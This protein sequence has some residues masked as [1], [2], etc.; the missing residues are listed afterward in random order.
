MSETFSNSL[1]VTPIGIATLYK[2]IS[3]GGPC[4]EI[5]DGIQVT[6]NK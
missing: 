1:A 4:T 5:N 6:L 3:N 2:L